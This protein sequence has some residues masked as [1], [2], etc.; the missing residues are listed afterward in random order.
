M[1]LAAHL[2]LELRDV[3]RIGGIPQG[4]RH[5]ALVSI[6]LG[7]VLP[8]LLLGRDLVVVREISQ[9]EEGQHVV[10][11][12]IRIHGTPQLVCDAPKS[13]AELF[14]VGVVHG[15]AKTKVSRKDAKTQ[16]KEED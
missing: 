15:L 5:A 3:F 13:I 2:L 6:D 8:Q 16:R 10:A 11:E 14:L 4:Q 12:V 1:H 9:E 7:I